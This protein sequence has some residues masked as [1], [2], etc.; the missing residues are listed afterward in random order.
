MPRARLALPRR[1]KHTVSSRLTHAVMRRGALS[2]GTLLIAQTP[3]C[4][5]R[6][7]RFALL[8]QST[9]RVL[10]PRRVPP[11]HVRWLH[12]N[13]VPPPT[14]C[15]TLPLPLQLAAWAGIRP[16]HLVWCDQPPSHVRRRH[17]ATFGATNVAS[18]PITDH[19]IT[20]HLSAGDSHS[21]RGRR[22]GCRRGPR[23]GGAATAGGAGS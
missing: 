8:S 18:R 20:D 21:K 13:P 17:I 5:S 22:R 9:R 19:P 4:L 15:P 1:H 3:P 7:S 6:P 12:S 11:H 14:H 10:H 16:V 2:R 23:R